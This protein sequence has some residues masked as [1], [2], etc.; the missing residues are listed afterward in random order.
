MT[1]LNIDGKEGSFP[2]FSLTLHDASITSIY[3]DVDLQ[4]ELVN[5]L[6]QVS[7]V[8]LFD[9]KDGVYERLTVQENVKFYHQWFGC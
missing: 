6:H 8:T 5:R 9:Y 2:S 4:E 3:I 7:E 1:T